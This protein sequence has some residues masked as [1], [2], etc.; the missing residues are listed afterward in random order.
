ML[1]VPFSFF[2][3]L[4]GARLINEKQMGFV[5]GFIEDSRQESRPTDVEWTSASLIKAGPGS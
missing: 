1:L 5:R 2:T 4:L 3:R